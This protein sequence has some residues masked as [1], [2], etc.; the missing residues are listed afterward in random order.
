MI[1]LLGV[2]QKL[3]GLLLV[4]VTGGPTLQ[5]AGCAAAELEQLLPVLLEEIEHPGDGAVLGSLIQAEGAA[6]DVDMEATGS[7]AMAE[8]TQLHGLFAQLCPGHS[9]KLP[10]QRHGVGHQLQPVVEGAVV[11]DVGEVSV[12][13]GDIQKRKGVRCTFTRT[14]NFQLHAEE[15]G[16][17]PMENGFRLIVIVMDALAFIQGMVTTG[18]IGTLIILIS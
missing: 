14:V 18:T 15:P 2:V 17:F 9:V 6:A 3:G 7:G 5:L 13:V 8:I 11:L 1:A 12:P 10:V 4:S 16:A